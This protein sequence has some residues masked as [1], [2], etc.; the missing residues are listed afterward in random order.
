MKICFFT[1]E[2]G[3]GGAERVISTLCNGRMGKECEISIITIIQGDWFYPIPEYI[4]TYGI[5]SYNEYFTKGK[6]KTLPAVCKGYYSTV[7]KIEPD[8]IVSFLP[9]P[10]F[11]SGHYRRKL[12]I[13][14]IGSERGNPYYQFAN[15]IYKFLGKYYYGKADGFVFQTKGARDFF[16][17]KIKDNSVII[18]NPVSNEGIKHDTS[19]ERR[20]EIVAVGRNTVEKN[21]PLLI[22]AFERVRKKHPDYVLKIYGRYE[23]SD[24]IVKQ[25]EQ[26]DLSNVVF[27]EGMATSIK[28]KIVDSSIYVLSS[29]S[30]GMPN[31]LIEAMSIGLPVV[32]TDCPSGGPKELIRN[33]INGRL[34]T[35]EDEVELAEAINSLIEDPGFA[36]KLG[37]EAMNILQEFSEEQ[38]CDK[39]INYINS[40]RRRSK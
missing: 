25:I 4:K 37:T 9:E 6:V 19:R 8:I 39:W 22:K 21:Y 30:E 33:N 12:G 7:K 28:Q 27:L 18:G 35:N 29:K 32:A 34:V 13:P 3:A 20:K 40:K 23:K 14:V 2:T 10:C 11:I 38:I 5:I 24:D 26:S 31:A 17:N 16:G 36:E 1:V 15:P